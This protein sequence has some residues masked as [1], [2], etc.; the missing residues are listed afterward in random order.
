[1]LCNPLRAGL[2]AWGVPLREWGADRQQASSL[3]RLPNGQPSKASR[4]TKSVFRFIW[5]YQRLSHAAPSPYAEQAKPCAVPTTWTPFFTLT[6]ECLPLKLGGLLDGADLEAGAVLLEHALAVVLPELLGGVLAGHA[7]ED[8]GAAG[9]VVEEACGLRRLAVLLEFEANF[10]SEVLRVSVSGRHT[11]N[12][13][14]A[15][16]DDDEHVVALLVLGDLGLGELLGHDG[17][18]WV[19]C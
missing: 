10:G 6:P 14:D 9:V 3:D 2:E 11:G 13:V 8:L 18:G 15:V 19:V 12:V 4:E 16:V 5:W 17:G 7:L 1:M